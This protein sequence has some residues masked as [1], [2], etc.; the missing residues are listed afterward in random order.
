MEPQVSD[1]IKS[2]H[3]MVHEPQGSYKVT[4]TARCKDSIAATS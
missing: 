1:Q 4:G 2:S 3:R